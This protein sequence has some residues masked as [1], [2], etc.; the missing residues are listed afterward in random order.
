MALIVSNN[1]IE[2]KTL[3]LFTCELY[4]MEKTKMVSIICK[5]QC[6]IA[7]SGFPI[8]TIFVCLMN[9]YFL[10]EKNYER[11]FIMYHFTAHAID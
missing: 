5:K 3:F 4:F 9:Q 10:Y 8:I 11:V 1:Y 2:I 6:A 7:Y